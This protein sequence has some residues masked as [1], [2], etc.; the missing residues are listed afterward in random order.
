MRLW[1]NVETF[2]WR[3]EECD[4]HSEY[5]FCLIYLLNIEIYFQVNDNWVYLT[6]DWYFLA[7]GTKSSGSTDVGMNV[8]FPLIT[9]TIQVF[10]RGA[11]ST[12]MAEERDSA[13]WCKGPNSNHYIR[14]YSLAYLW[15]D[16]RSFHMGG[17]CLE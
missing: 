9:S 4:I 17:I 3:P 14:M 5:I 10:L 7:Q 6:C 1:R 12:F 2:V 16:V 15:K 13:C 8:L 11:R